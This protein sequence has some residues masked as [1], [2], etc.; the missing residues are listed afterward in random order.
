[1]FRRS[2]CGVADYLQA[3]WPWIF[4]LRSAFTFRNEEGGGRESDAPS[5]ASPHSCGARSQSLFRFKPIVF[6]RSLRT[7]LFDPTSICQF[8]YCSLIEPFL[9]P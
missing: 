3:C 2:P 7:A 6:R 1:M 4:I 8:G 9:G 5:S